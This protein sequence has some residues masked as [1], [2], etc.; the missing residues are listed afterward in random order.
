MRDLGNGFAEEVC[1]DVDIY[2][3]EAYEDCSMETRYCDEAYTECEDVMQYRSEPVFE[4]RCDYETWQWTEVGT[5]HTAGR[6]HE[7]PVWSD[8]SPT[9]LQR[10]TRTERYGVSVAWGEGEQYAIEPDSEAA[11]AQ[12]PMGAVVAV[13]VS[14]LGVVRDCKVK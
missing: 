6:D 14:N 9:A 3:D 13:E 12:W 2:C 11:F 10:T 4:D 8:V 5:Q 7:A 1:D